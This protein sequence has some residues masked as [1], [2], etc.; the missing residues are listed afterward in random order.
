MVGCIGWLPLPL[1]LP[2]LH[3][4]AHSPLRTP[5][6]RELRLKYAHQ[7]HHQFGIKYDYGP[8]YADVCR[9]PP[10]AC[11]RRASCLGLKG[12]QTVGRGTLW[13][14]LNTRTLRPGLQPPQAGQSPLYCYIYTVYSCCLSPLYRSLSFC[15]KGEGTA[16]SRS[17][18][19]RKRSTART[20]CI[21]PRAATTGYRA[22]P[23]EFHLSN[24][25]SDRIPHHC[26]ASF[27]VC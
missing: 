11:H 25:E 23:V 1:P 15:A 3:A 5:S 24:Q 10:A 9:L 17:D 13:N 21:L 14:A 6:S 8:I 27:C 22:L 7:C 16:G 19:V 26:S 4:S 2:L 20:H 12:G 18:S